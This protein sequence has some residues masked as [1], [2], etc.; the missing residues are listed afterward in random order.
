MEF[1]EF[2][3]ANQKKGG[4]KKICMPIT[5]YVSMAKG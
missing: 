2:V 4:S 3:E 5:I 1:Q